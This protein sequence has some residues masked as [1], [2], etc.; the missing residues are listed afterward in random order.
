MALQCLHGGW[1][2]SFDREIQAL[3]A[4][5][6]DRIFDEWPDPAGLGPP[7]S[8]GMDACTQG[9]APAS[10]CARPAGERR[11][12]STTCA[13]AAT[14][15][16]SR[17]GVHSSARSF[18]CRSFCRAH[19][20]R[21]S[22]SDWSLSQLLASLHDDIQQRLS[23]GAKD[24][25]TIRGRR[26]TPAR[27]SGSTCSTRICPS[28]T[29]RPRRMSST[30]WA[31]F[32]QQIDVVV[33]DRQYSPFIFTYENET[34]IPAESVY[35]VFEAKQTADAD[36]VA[37]AQEKVAS[38]RRLHR[39][40][41]PIPHANGVYPAKPLIPILGGLLTFE[42]EWSPRWAPSL[43]K[44]LTAGR[45]RGPARHRL[46]RVARALLLR[47][48]GVELLVRRREQAGDRVP[49][50]ADLAAAVQ[51]NRA[52]DRRRGLRTVADQVEG[53]PTFAMTAETTTATRSHRRMRPPVKARDAT[54]AAQAASTPR[55][56]AQAPSGD[57]PP[58]PPAPSRRGLPQGSGAG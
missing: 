19:P 28:A 29:R 44:A 15:R 23:L 48:S 14:A 38:V 17:L 13:R 46:R 21:S 41:L 35:A 4:T 50:Q 16:R 34:I 3:F 8:N 9:R 5:L 52:D 54:R 1:G 26:A 31:Y 49:V 53:Q 47:R 43:E 24:A 30:A 51:R 42:S 11:S 57:N 7:I 27:M 58:L 18:R 45:R 12:P 32:S 55:P 37:Y 2:G 36:L 10:C 20:A 40:S 56:V 33:F 25:S 22:M 39:T 6:A